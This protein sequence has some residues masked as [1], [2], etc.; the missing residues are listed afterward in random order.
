MSNSRSSASITFPQKLW[1]IVNECDSGAIGWGKNG[2]TIIIDALKFQN[3]FLDEF[4]FIFKSKNFK[5]FV[6]QLNY[7]GFRKCG[8]FNNVHEFKNEFFIQD[9][10]DLLEF[11]NRNPRLKEIESSSE[12]T[13]QSKMAKSNRKREKSVSMKSVFLIMLKS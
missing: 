7:Y 8:Y 11:V 13:F 5:S 3:E 4:S 2:K 6:R 12:D 10:L 1:H 9:R